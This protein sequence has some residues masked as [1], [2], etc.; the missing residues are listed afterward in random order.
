MSQPLPEELFLKD[1]RVNAAIAWILVALFVAI[2]VVGFL[3]VQ[4]VEMAVAA[5]AAFVAIT[6]TVVFRSWK[7]TVPW[8]LLVL[9]GIPLLVDLTQSSFFSEVVTG[10][11]VA[12]LAMLVVVTLELTTTVRMT[13][14]FAIVFTIIAT[15]ATAGFWAV[16]SAASAV[17]LGTAFVETNDELMY[18]FTAALVAGLVAGGVFRWYFRRYRQ[19]TTDQGDA[20]VA[21]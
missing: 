14:G 12:A 2:A 4:F 7:R 13:S 19:A 5:I 16:G 11:S 21:T 15:L 17:Y 8:P 10:F 1:A 6:P 9:A 3:T 18:I 20:E